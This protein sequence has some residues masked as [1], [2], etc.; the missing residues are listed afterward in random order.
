MVSQMTQATLHAFTA[1]LFMGGVHFTKSDAEYASYREA[2]TEAFG[3]LGLAAALPLPEGAADYPTWAEAGLPAVL[4]NLS[5][6]RAR[7]GGD[8]TAF[9]VF[10]VS[11]FGVRVVA[12]GIFGDPIEG[13]DDYPIL[14][15]SLDDLGVT[16]NA[17]RDLNDRISS[18]SMAVSGDT[19]STSFIMDTARLFAGGVLTQ[20]VDQSDNADLKAVMHAGFLDLGA[21][22]REQNKELAA[23]I[24]AGNAQILALFGQLQQQLLDAGL[25]KEQAEAL[26]EGDPGTFWER[27]TRWLGGGSARDAAEAA[28][29]TALDF[30]PAGS[31][32]KLGLK[33]VEAVRSA[34]KK[35]G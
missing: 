27:T 8:A 18:A 29:W 19:V 11:F 28:L 6:L 33:L 4:G 24:E 9:P 32:V 26:T 3:E 14:V 30:V 23:L 7:I 31:A 2:I 22:M 1:G 10:I 25:T 13:L 34:T 5:D 16:D 15:G 21:Q 12:Q 35:D 17:L 20:L